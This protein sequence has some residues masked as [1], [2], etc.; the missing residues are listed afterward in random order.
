MEGEDF[1]VNSVCTVWEE[2]KVSAP[3]HC[4]RNSKWVRKTIQSIRKL[5]EENTI[6]TKGE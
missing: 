1:K 4:K 5:I 2:E 6:K 3:S